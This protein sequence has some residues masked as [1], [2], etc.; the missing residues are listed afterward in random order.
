MAFVSGRIIIQTTEAQKNHKPQKQKKQSPPHVNIQFET[1]LIEAKIRKSIY[2][3]F[4]FP[5]KKETNKRKRQK[6][7]KTQ[8]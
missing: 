6:H 1:N 7:T 4:P 8:G 5:K 3:F 2:I